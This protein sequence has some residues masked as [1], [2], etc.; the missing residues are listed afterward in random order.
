[1]LILAY[2]LS[3]HKSQGSEFGAIVLPLSTQHYRML[4]RKLLYTAVTRAKKLCVLVGSRKAFQIAITNFQEQP[5]YTALKER[6]MGE[7]FLHEK[8]FYFF[9]VL[10]KFLF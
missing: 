5:R 7:G 6:I 8:N 4:R 1:M 3:V 2:A 9:Y 10:F